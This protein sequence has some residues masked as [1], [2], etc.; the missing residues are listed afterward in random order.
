[1]NRK[2][3]KVTFS[4]IQRPKLHQVTQRLDESLPLN[5]DAWTQVEQV[6]MRLTEFA[7]STLVVEAAAAIA[8]YADEQAQSGYILGQDDLVQELKQLV[9]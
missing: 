5:T 8:L 4:S 1:M 9:A 2:K 7:P 6:L 3:S